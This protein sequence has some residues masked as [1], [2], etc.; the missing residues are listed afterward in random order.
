MVAWCT[1]RSMVASVMAWSF[2][3]YD[4]IWPDRLEQ[5]LLGH[6]AIPIL[7]EIAQQLEALASKRNLAIL[8]RDA[9]IVAGWRHAV[10]GAERLVALRQILLRVGIEIAEGRRQAV[11]AMLLGNAA[12]RPQRI[13]QALGQCDE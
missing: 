9:E 12:E 5:L 1:S 7:H 11:A 4:N 10:M 3:G 13:L 6:Q 2:V 8:V